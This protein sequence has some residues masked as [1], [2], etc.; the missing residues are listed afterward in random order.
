MQTPE[1]IK[2]L[3]ET[4]AAEVQQLSEAA[5]DSLTHKA[6]SASKH[7]DSGKHKND[8]ATYDAHDKA[9][10]AHDRAHWA[11]REK[12]IDLVNNATGKRMAHPDF[13]KTLN[14][15]LQQAAHHWNERERHTKLLGKMF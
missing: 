3:A 13:H 8:D 14:H 9:M 11:H 10:D 7:A 12:A 5:F 1:T 2:S 6:A 15:H 4:Y